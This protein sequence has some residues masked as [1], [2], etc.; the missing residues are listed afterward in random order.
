MTEFALNKLL[1]HVAKR[2]LLVIEN[3]QV[4]RSIV[5]PQIGNK[6][7]ICMFPLPQFDETHF[8]FIVCSG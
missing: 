1:V 5:E 2:D 3:Y 6:M 7:K 4:V 8:P